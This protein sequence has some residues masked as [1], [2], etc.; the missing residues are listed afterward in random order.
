MKG[1]PHPSRLHP[2]ERALL[3]L[4][5]GEARYCL[6]VERVDTLR[7]AMLE[8]RGDPEADV[9]V[10]VPGAW[11]GAAL[12]MEHLHSSD[13]LESASWMLLLLVVPC[14]GNLAL[15]SLKAEVDI[16]LAAAGSSF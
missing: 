14:V 10:S 1:F 2:F 4:T 3:E 8:V 5:L 15:G 11:S 6:A 12:P 13:G 7:K 9:V 16:M